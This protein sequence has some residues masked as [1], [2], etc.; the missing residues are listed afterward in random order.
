MIMIG[1]ISNLVFKGVLAA[2]MGSRAFALRFARL[3][4]VAFLIGVGLIALW[5]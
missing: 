2:A 3:A 1:G 5:P 4:S